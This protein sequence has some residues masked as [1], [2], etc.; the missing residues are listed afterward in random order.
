VPPP[1]G[2]PPNGRPPGRKSPKKY[3]VSPKSAAKKK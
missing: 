2:R 1:A 3:G